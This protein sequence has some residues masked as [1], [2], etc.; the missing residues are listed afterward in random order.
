MEKPPIPVSLPNDER[1]REIQVKTHALNDY[2]QL[3]Q[4]NSPLSSIDETE[5]DPGDKNNDRDSE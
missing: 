3:G 2:D 1:V 5:Q 4:L